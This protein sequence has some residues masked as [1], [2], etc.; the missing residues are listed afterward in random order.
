[1][2]ISDNNIDTQKLREAM[3]EAKEKCQQLSAQR[4]VSPFFIEKICR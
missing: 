3:R 1:M 4:Y 2:C